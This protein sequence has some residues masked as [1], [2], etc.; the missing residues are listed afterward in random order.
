[1]QGQY[2]P[3][4]A[5]RAGAARSDPELSIKR[6]IL[7]RSDAFAHEPNADLYRVNL[8]GQMLDRYDE[9]RASGASEELCVQRVCREFADIPQRM[10]QAGFERAHPEY[11]GRPLLSEAEADAYLRQCGEWT[12]KTAAGAA[13]CVACCAPLM[14]AMGFDALLGYAATDVL[15]LIGLIG[16]FAMIALGVYMFATARKPDRYEDVKRG[17]FAL[18]ARLRKK[19]SAL[20]EWMH[21]AARRRRARGIALCV[22]CVIPIFAGATLDTMLG[23]ETFATLGVGG[24]FLM[25]GAGVYEI[26]AANSEKKDVDRLLK[27]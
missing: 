4:S 12:R 27:G 11:A 13:L 19:L 8:L 7:E 20:R 15:G 16:L 9:L 25:I 22:A 17:R 14:A 5:R 10:A 2:R 26:V 21:D 6:F 1:M 23:A 24:M 18:S 3:Q